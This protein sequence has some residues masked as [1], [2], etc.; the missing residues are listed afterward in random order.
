MLT[1]PVG[2]RSAIQREGTESNGQGRVVRAELALPRRPHFLLPQCCPQAS[3]RWCGDTVTVWRYGV[4]EVTSLDALTSTGL[5]LTGRGD[6]GLEV[7]AGMPNLLI[8]RQDIDRLHTGEP[9][10]EI[11]SNK[12]QK[13][14]SKNTHPDIL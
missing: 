5:L 8:L 13:R 6:C 10:N 1:L 9:G 7:F 11:N 2:K 3:M 12:L 14:K 4:E